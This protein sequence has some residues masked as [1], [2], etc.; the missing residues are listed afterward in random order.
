[1]QDVHTSAWIVKKCLQGD[2]VKGRTV[3]LTV[4]STF[5]MYMV[6]YL[7]R[8]RLK[9]HNIALTM[10][11]AAYVVSMGTDGRIVSQGAPSKALLRDQIPIDEIGHER[12]AIELE[13]DL[14]TDDDDGDEAKKASAYGAKARY[15]LYVVSGC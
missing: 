9:T 10:P 4:S 13:V 15:L 11:V 6:L 5:Q 1:M 7:T 8:I 14:D 2:Q 3:I 12:E